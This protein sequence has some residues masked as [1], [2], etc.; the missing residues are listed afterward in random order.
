MRCRLIGL[1]ST[2]LSTPAK[3]IL[4]PS[5]SRAYAIIFPTSLVLINLFSAHLLRH[6]AVPLYQFAPQWEE[7]RENSNWMNQK[8]NCVLKTGW[9]YTIKRNSDGMTTMPTLTH[10][11]TSSAGDYGNIVCTTREYGIL[12]ERDVCTIQ[13]DSVPSHMICVFWRHDVLYPVVSFRMI[14]VHAISDWLLVCVT[15]VRWD[16]WS[17]RSI[18]LG[19]ASVKVSYTHQL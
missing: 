10:G 5:Y 18:P 11:I 12:Y 2:Q 1:H 7:T 8:E 19:I 3:R 4:N 15:M 17:Y 13:G 9:A 16:Q 14:D 6:F